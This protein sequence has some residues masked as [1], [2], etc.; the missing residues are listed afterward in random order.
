[1]ELLNCTDSDQVIT[2][3]SLAVT[4]VIAQKSLTQLFSSEF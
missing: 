1:M 2:C 3:I 4:E